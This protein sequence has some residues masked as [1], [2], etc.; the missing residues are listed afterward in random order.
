M[1]NTPLSESKI[2]SF[3]YHQPSRTLELEF[4]NGKIYQYYGIPENLCN[5]MKEADS[6]NE[7]FHLHIKNVY[8]FARV[9]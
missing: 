9:D 1:Q 5:A 2:R 4:L 7:F 6:M 3:G 8:A